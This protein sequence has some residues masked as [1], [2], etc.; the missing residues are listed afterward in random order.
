MLLMTLTEQRTKCI[1]LLD[2]KKYKKDFTMLRQM[3]ELKH[4]NQISNR[5]KKIKNRH[6]SNNGDSNI[7]LL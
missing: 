3:I 4:T 2:V 5:L 6:D 1:V 7:R